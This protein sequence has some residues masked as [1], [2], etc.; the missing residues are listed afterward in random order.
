MAAVLLGS[1]AAGTPALAEAP[2]PAVQGPA[3]ADAAPVPDVA[4]DPASVVPP[5]EPL[6]SVSAVVVTPD[7]AEVIT[8]EAEP[9][10]ITEIIA[11]LRE[12]PGVVSVSVDTPVSAV[13]AADPYAAEQWSLEALNL[14]TLPAGTPDGAGLT[15][16]VLDTGV[17]AA[18]ED[19][20][21]RVRCDLGADFAPDAATYGAARGCVD[22]HGHGTHVA[23]QISA[24]TGNGLG[25]AGVSNAQVLPVRVLAANG[26]GTSASVARGIT[27]AV[28]HGAAV[29]NMSLSG[30]Y[31]SAYDSAVRYATDRGV[32]VVAAAGN[33]RMEGN[34]VNYPAASP[35]AIAVAA[36]TDTGESAYFSYRGPTNLVAAPGWSVLSTDSNHDYVYRSGTSMAAPHVAGVLV[37]YR[38]A[39]PGASVA[40]VRAAV[41]ETAIDL[42]APGWDDA[43]GYGLID[44]YELL[45]GHEEPEPVV[46]TAPA[47]PAIGTATAANASVVVRW[48]APD[49]GGSPITGYTL[50]TYKGASAVRTTTVAGSATSA[51]VTGLTNGTAYTFTV[52]AGNAV[53]RGPASARSAAVVPRTRPAAPAI[54]VPSVGW[55][56]AVV[57]WAAP[58]NGGSAITGYTVRAY[59]GTSLVK[60]TPVKGTATSATITGLAGGKAHTFTVVAANA[61]GAG[62]VSTRSATVTPRAPARPGVPKIG[63]PSAGRASAVVRWSAA[64]DNGSAVRSYTVRAYRGTSLVR[65]TVVTGSAASVTVT[66]LAAGRAHTFRVT[67]ANAVGAGSASARSAAV[68]PRR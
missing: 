50:R 59:R 51:T 44:A 27:W 22:P 36:S 43:T 32:I 17:H 2:A 20:A 56:S 26:G 23:G 15:V 46:A 3:G 38:A 41:Q 60:T 45:T 13:G 49:T 11:D 37:R 55:S 67:A 57:R 48:T 7:G 1:I 65:T 12:E 47:A 4:P 53:G 63:A 58:G 68:T 28:E 35:G 40:Q 19:L 39:H 18:H 25:I 42:E 29:I 61:L 21:G 64:A 66:G 10:E 24:R 52:T 14:P 30:P 33:N 34:A 62:P 6:G 16:A 8:R 9:S 54:G 5:D 31:N